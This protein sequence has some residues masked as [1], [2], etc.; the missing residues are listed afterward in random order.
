ME[1]DVFSSG[2]IQEIETQ[3]PSLNQVP[4]VVRRLLNREE[5][6]LQVAFI[7]RSQR[8]QAGGAVPVFY[9]IEGTRPNGT[10]IEATINQAGTTIEVEVLEQLGD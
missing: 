8:P 1:V 6:N 7:E 9:E 5:P 4:S 2:Q 10:V 3:L